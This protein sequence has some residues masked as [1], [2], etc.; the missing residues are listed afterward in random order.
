[1]H[2][3]AS[4]QVQQG[5]RI[6]F[7]CQKGH[8]TA[9]LVS[10]LQPSVVNSSIQCRRPGCDLWS[11]HSTPPKVLRVATHEWASPTV[12]SA[13]ELADDKGGRNWLP[14]ERDRF[15]KF[16][17]Q[18]GDRGGL[19]LVRRKTFFARLVRFLLESLTRSSRL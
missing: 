1:M 16:I 10:A 11:H 6:Y 18:H 14:G 9:T 2:I 17:M 12:D 8:V 5:R 3:Q 15:V 7:R 19:V 4:L 13:D